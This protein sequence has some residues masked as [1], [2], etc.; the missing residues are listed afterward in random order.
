MEFQ[1]LTCTQNSTDPTAQQPQAIKMQLGQS[2]CLHLSNFGFFQ[3][4]LYYFEKKAKI[5][6]WLNKE[7]LKLQALNVYLHTIVYK[8]ANITSAFSLLNDSCVLS[9]Y[10]Y[11][12]QDN[13]TASPESQ[14]YLVKLQQLFHLS[15]LRLLTSFIR[16]CHVQSQ[17][18]Y[19]TCLLVNLC[20]TTMLF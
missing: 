1:I 7:F 11:K 6:S 16:I 3:N 14:V 13:A 2:F 12:S 4:S 20:T 17:L 18:I 5:S 19:L 9:T 10:P 8:I 15:Q